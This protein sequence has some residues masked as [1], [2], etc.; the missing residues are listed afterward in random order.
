[1]VVQLLLSHTS[2]TRFEKNYDKMK[3]VIYN[4]YQN[5]TTVITIE[6]YFYKYKQEHLLF[7]FQMDDFSAMS[8][9]RCLS[10]TGVVAVEREFSLSYSSSSRMGFL[11]NLPSPS[12][13]SNAVG[14]KGI[15]MRGLKNSVCIQLIISQ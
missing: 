11:M 4:L 13:S 3:H 1:M 15:S 8:G 14:E 5:T 7:L 9:L 6:T 2:L 12:K 10:V